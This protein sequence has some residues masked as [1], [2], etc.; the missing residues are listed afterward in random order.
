MQFIVKYQVTR[1][2][3]LFAECATKREAGAAFDQAAQPGRHVEVLE[4]AEQDWYE[5]EYI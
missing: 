5:V 3:E 4:L 2:G 1:D